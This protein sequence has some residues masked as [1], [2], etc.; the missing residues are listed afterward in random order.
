MERQL[1]RED[2]LNAKAIHL[3]NEDTIYVELNDTEDVYGSYKG[4]EWFVKGNFWDYWDSSIM[5]S[6]FQYLTPDEAFKLLDKWQTER[7]LDIQADNYRL[8]KAITFATEKHSGQLRKS[9]KI[10]YILHP[11]EV[12]QILYSMRADT[13][14]LIAG[15]LHDTVEDTDTT[16]D[17]IREIFGDDVAELVASNSE[18]KSKTWDERKQHTITELAKADI[19]VKMLLLADKLSN[20]RSIAY[21]YRNIGDELWKRFNAPKE[22]QAWYYSGIQDSIFDMQLN[23][24]CAEA[25]WEFVGLYK[26]VFVKYYLDEADEF[27]YQQSDDGTIYGMKKGNP[28]W[29]EVKVSIPDATAKPDIPIYFRLQWKPDEAV[30]IPRHEAELLEDIWNKAFWDCHKYD[31]RD[32]SYTIFGSERRQIDIKIKERHFVLHCE[33]YG[34]SCK[35]INGKDEYQF[36]YTLDYDNSER[37]L[38]QLRMKHGIDMELADIFIKEFGS[39]NGTVLFEKACKELGVQYKFYSY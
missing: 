7:E 16:L 2:I 12:L 18:D 9:T 28:Q 13:N 1:T 33:D 23:S 8:N 10:P 24:D 29:L 36:A 20:I 27:L 21:D 15:V 11:L 3:Y 4:G 6:Y 30:L 5:L 25:Y 31:M 19:R 38:V 37:L 39:D 34:D 22:K 17:E 26:D 32:D 35:N 14:L